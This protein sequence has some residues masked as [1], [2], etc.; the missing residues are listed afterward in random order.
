MDLKD[1][2]CFLLDLDGTFYRGNMMID[3]SLEFIDRVLA[4]GREYLFLTNNSSQTADYYVEKLTRMGLKTD[5]SHVLTSGE[6]TCDKLHALYPGKGA[7]V[8]GNRYL[9]QE[10]RERGIDVDAEHPDLVVV[11]FDTEVTYQ[12]LW[13]ACDLIRYG[14][15]YIATHHDI[16]CPTETGF[17]PDIG[18]ILA[19][20]E[21]STG[22]RPDI[23]IGKPY[24]GIVEAALHRT[25]L[26]PNQLAMV[27]DRLYTDVATGLQ[28]GMLAIAVLS[29]ETTREM[30]AT[31]D[32]VPDLVFDCLGDMVP[33]L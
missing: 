14:L 17:K 20:I 10:F 4:T 3:G 5:R 32:I 13:I 24:S 31:S 19:Y 6:A 23:I 29:G 2:R 8:V 33:L 12:K 22:K 30:L 15:P 16:N 7:Y 9:I 18:A 25:G 11:G 28:N 21:A 1:V 27:G 26:Q